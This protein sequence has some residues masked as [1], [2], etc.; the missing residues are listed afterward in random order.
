MHSEKSKAVFLDRNGVLNRELG[1]YVMH[2]E[3]FIINDGVVEA[4]RIFR[5]KNYLLI[6]IS[7]QGGISKGI[8]TREQVDYLHLHLHRA[9]SRNIALVGPDLPLLYELTRANL[10]HALLQ[11]GHGVDRGQ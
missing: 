4:L 8:C 1:N 7:N 6:V 11:R 2:L 10:P 5:E 3:E 9:L